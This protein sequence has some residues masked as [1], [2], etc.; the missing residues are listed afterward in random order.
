MG[1]KCWLVAILAGC[2]LSASYAQVS[3]KGKVT[4]EKGRPVSGAN[5]RVSNSLNGSSTNMEGRFDLDLPE[6]RHRIRVTHLGF[7]QGVY[8]TDGK[9]SGEIVIR[10]KE[11]YIN[12]D[13]VVVTGTGTH[14]RM[15]QSPIP[16]KVITGEDLKEA[17]VTN[18]QDAMTKLN[19]GVSF[20]ENGMGVTMNMN[21]LTDKYVLI[22]VNGKRLAGEDTYTRIDMTDV[23]RIE[24]LNGAA[25]ALYGSDAIAGVV[26]IITNDN[27]NKANITSNTRYGS[28]NRF[29]QSI[30]ADINAGKFGSHTSYQRQQADGWQ[31]NPYTEDK[32]GQLVETNKQASTAF[33]SNMV[34]QR[35][36]FD[37][38]DRLSFYLRGGLYHYNTDRPI[39]QGD[40]KTNYDMRRE[41]YSYGAGAQYM[42]DRNSYL[43][44]DYLSDNNSVYKDYFDGKRSGETDMTKRIH[45]H[46]L[47]VK[48]IFRLGKYNKFSAGTEYIK[49][50]LD[51]ETDNID[52]RS[53]YT[54]ALYAQ[55][56]VHIS[57]RFQ[58]YAGLRYTYHKSFNSYLT[59]NVALL[60]KTGCFNFRGS[61]AS[62]F[63]SPS[64]S[65]MYT[66]TEKKTGGGT[67]LTIGNENLKPEKNDNVTLSA[68]YTNSRFSMSVSA[69]MNNIR[70]L[71]NY[72]VFTPEE[73][74]AYNRMHQ[75]DF[76]EV[77]QRD[78]IDKARI[79]GINVNVNSYL[80]AGF[81]FNGG[82][83][84]IDGKDYGKDRPLDKSV[85]H[86][87][88]V[89]AV[90]SHIWNAYQLN[91]NFNGRIQGRRYSQSYGYAPKFSL[92]NLNTTHTFTLKSLILEPGAGIENLFD[93][94]DDRPF[95]SNYATLTPGRTYYVSLS[96]R[97]KQ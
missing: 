81:S 63:R 54:A 51:S 74:D 24:I 68:E 75:T 28:K 16:V 85:K 40:N 88:T 47:N 91:I 69:F 1:K 33:H 7:E 11:K 64:L 93:Y 52:G 94:V 44:A 3:L 62:G 76:D 49:E 34:S 95:N 14:R 53:T 20:M 46:N 67:R 96:V 78:N 21:G 9:E 84:F 38:T 77:Q 92:W 22:L 65:E 66:E 19:P 43:N 82:Y 35:F 80:G 86:S 48:G 55:D 83:N 73:T 41:T 45:Y 31:L 61:Y 72:R 71:I 8:E 89:A 32:N 36:T 30:N 15:S 56:E 27:R 87:G 79:K 59:P 5:I 25:S 39:P 10:L 26:N 42:I 12:L 50:R 2:S 97:F 58:A 6:G 70:D 17:S 90:W 18:F 29:I 13:Q 4:D 37:P 23:K 60:Y 57:E